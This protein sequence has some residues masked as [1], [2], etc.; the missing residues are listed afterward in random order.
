MKISI[1]LDG[2]LY[3]HPVFFRE[4]MSLFQAAGHQV[5][6]LTGH[7][8]E[9][10]SHDRKKLLADG[11]SPDFYLG[12]TPAYMPLNGSVFKRNMIVAHNI[13]I[14]FDDLDYS[15]PDSERLFEEHELA[16]TRLIRM[17][18][19]KEAARRHGW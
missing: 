7:K 6:I 5:G 1:D 3:A 14:H 10:E 2:T 16:R 18:K 15:N 17:P 8:A 19:D 12:R 13:D 9:S 4:L 11:F